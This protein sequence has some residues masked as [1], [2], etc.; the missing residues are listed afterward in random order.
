MMIGFIIGCDC[1]S[2]SS[3][4]DAREAMILEIWCNDEIEFSRTRAVSYVYE[5]LKEK[6]EQETMFSKAH[7][8]SSLFFKPPGRG[9]F[10]FHRPPAPWNAATKET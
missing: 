5:L 2:C 10:S 3:R 6:P 9:S 4:Y 8:M 1:I 7:T